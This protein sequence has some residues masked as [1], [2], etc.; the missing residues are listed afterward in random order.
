MTSD[1]PTTS[2]SG[3]SDG[4]A[5]LTIVV[6]DGAGASTTHHLTCAPPGGDHPSPE[7]ACRV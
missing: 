2:T 1:S 5:D 6:V 7:V 4:A 3:P